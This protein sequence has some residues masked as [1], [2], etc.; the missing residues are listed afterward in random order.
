MSGGGGLDVACDSLRFR[1]LRRR[2]RQ[3]QGVAITRHRKMDERA[4]AREQDM[5]QNRKE[6]T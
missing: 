6:G 4:H 5:Q 2:F 1:R 3:E